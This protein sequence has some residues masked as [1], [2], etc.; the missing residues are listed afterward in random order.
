MPLQPSFESPSNHSRPDRN[1][2]ST[3]L[4]PDH[5]TASSSRD[6]SG[7]SLAPLSYMRSRSVVE[8][9]LG[10]LQYLIILNEG[11]SQVRVRPYRIAN[12]H[13]NAKSWRRRQK[14]DSLTTVSRSCYRLQNGVGKSGSGY[15][16]LTFVERARKGG[17]YSRAP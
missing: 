8:V 16:H 9:D 4:G 6:R 14:L 15:D 13:G 5:S 11:T 1:T 17:L 12:G 3:C 2:Q 7:K 10:P